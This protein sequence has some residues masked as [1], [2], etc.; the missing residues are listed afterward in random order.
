[1]EHGGT[2]RSK[3]ARRKA[4]GK[5]CKHWTSPHPLGR[6]SCVVSSSSTAGHSVSVSVIAAGGRT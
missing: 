1:M 3:Q 4:A 6:H 2:R 5:L